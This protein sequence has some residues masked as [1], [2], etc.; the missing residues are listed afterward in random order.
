MHKIVKNID[1][2][3]TNDKNPKEWLSMNDPV[4]T[5]N[6]VYDFQAA[7]SNEMSIKM[8]Q[9]IWLAPESIQPKNNPG[10]CKATDGTNIG[11]IPSNYVQIVGEMKKK[12]NQDAPKDSEIKYNMEE[13]FQ[14]SE[15][16]QVPLSETKEKS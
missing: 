5:A 3:D 13:S 12:V 16:S 15:N 10:W 8:G 11:L 9:K 1:T 2:N 4:F 7:R 6:V 14:N